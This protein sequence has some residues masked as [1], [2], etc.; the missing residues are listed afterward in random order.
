MILEILADICEADTDALCR[1]VRAA[2]KIAKKFSISYESSKE[3]PENIGVIKYMAL[4][5]VSL[6]EKI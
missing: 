4:D 6:C 2:D 3:K 1:L 5:F